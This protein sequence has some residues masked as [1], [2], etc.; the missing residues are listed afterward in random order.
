MIVRGWLSESFGVPFWN[1]AGKEKG[2]LD[3]LLACLET[4]NSG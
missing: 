4:L 2:A 1:N 3:P